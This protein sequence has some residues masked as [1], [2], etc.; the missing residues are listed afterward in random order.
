MGIRRAGT[1][2]H[3]HGS[4]T[5]AF[6][7]LRLFLI[8]T[9]FCFSLVFLRLIR[10][11]SFG[12]CSFFFCLQQLRCCSCSA[13]S[14]TERRHDAF[15]CDEIVCFRPLCGAATSASFFRWVSS[16][17]A[18]LFSNEQHHHTEQKN[19]QLLCL[20]HVNALLRLSR[21]AF[22]PLCTRRLSACSPLPLLIPF[23]FFASLTPPFPSLTLTRLRSPRL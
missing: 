23:S 22:C 10:A 15:A 3:P 13:P 8:L 14:Y 5:R 7:C 18:G 11:R 1:N 21:T 12:L 17:A 6:T 19:T 2:T 16:P 20:Y 9:E 4:D